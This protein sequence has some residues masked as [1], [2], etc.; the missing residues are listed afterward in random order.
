MA[1]P[2]FRFVEWKNDSCTIRFKTAQRVG[3][4]FD[5][6]LILR[7]REPITRSQ[8]RIRGKV[9]DA[10]HDCMH[11]CESH[12][13][14]KGLVII[15]ATAHADII[16][17]QPFE[18]KYEFEG[19]VRRYFPDV[20]VAWGDELWVVE[21]KDDKKAEMPEEKARFELISRLLSTHGIHFILWKKSEICAEPRLS[22]ARNV[23]R[24]QQCDVSLFQRERL[25]MKFAKSPVIAIGS[26]DDDTIR[27]V[28]RLVV[29][30]ALHIDWSSAL[31]KA[32][33]VSVSPFDQQPWP[34]TR[35]LDATIERAG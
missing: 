12:N 3:E 25:R 13:E 5:L 16:A 10:L 6:R 18:L 9:P 17:V 33:W 19:K 14:L 35:T 11:H 31:S 30:G 28:L 1:K 29:E 23:F 15:V 20:L 2:K 21:I 4:P 7:I 8:R 22:T 26:L 32:T 27:S 24:Y 34:A